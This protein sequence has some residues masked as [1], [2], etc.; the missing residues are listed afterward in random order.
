MS[1]QAKVVHM[2][3]PQRVD[4]DRHHAVESVLHLR[5]SR[6]ARVGTQQLCKLL[7]VF[8]LAE[9][10]AVGIILHAEFARELRVGLLR[11]LCVGLAQSLIA[12]VLRSGLWP[13]TFHST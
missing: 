12:F 8:F 2:D 6:R 3:V 9:S 4:D 10:E 11:S 5:A 13:N 1:L 7:T